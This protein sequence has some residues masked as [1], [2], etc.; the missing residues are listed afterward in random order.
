MWGQLIHVVT[1]KVMVNQ[2]LKN[3]IQPY[4]E[5]LGVQLWNMV[6]LMLHMRVRL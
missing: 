4:F 5:S 2:Q 3:Q 6:G 1:I